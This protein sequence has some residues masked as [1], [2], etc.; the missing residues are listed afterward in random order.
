MMVLAVLLMMLMLQSRR[1][2]ATS[3]LLLP[4]LPKR[5]TSHFQPRW[6]QLQERLGALSSC[7]V[8]LPGCQSPVPAV[9]ALTAVLVLVL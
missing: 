9:P 8:M 2:P 6:S 1:E 3:K 4:A 7:A 5:D